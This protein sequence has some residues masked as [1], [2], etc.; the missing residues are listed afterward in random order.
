[1]NI[2]TTLNTSLDN[3]TLSGP[4][5]YNNVMYVKIHNK[6]DNF[7]IQTPKMYV[8]DIDKSKDYIE[9]KFDNYRKNESLDSFYRLFREVENKV[10]EL[11]SLNA[12]EWFS[13]D[14]DSNVIRENLFKSSIVFPNDLKDSLGLKLY[15]PKNKDN[16]NF[17]VY[18]S[19]KNKIE[20]VENIPEYSEY[21]TLFVANELVISRSTAYIIWEVS[22]M[23]VFPK[24]EKI[25]GFNFRE[26]KKEKINK[27]LLTIP[28]KEEYEETQ[29]VKPEEPE[30]QKPEIKE[31]S[32][33]ETQ[34]VKPEIKE[35]SNEE[36]NEETQSVK[37]EEPEKQS[38][39]EFI[40]R[41]KKK[42]VP[43]I[44]VRMLDDVRSMVGT[45]YDDI[46]IAP[47]NN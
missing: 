15:I 4:E 46:S 12:S 40:K 11:V 26:D 20:N 25:T 19:K 47:N 5:N 22:Q 41:K 38:I 27:I 10:C 18:N 45:V 30:K 17:E 23:Q 7:Y 44:N 8:Q 24:R 39:E 9:L 31:E 6:S 29:S 35:E 3:I 16:I 33:E 2:L 1:M 37:P 13:K 43:S 36:T 14:I 21:I 42:V 28:P 34:S 32:N